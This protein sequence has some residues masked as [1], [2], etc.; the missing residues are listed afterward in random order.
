MFKN[1]EIK[2]N[3]NLFETIFFETIFDYNKDEV[4][5][6]IEKLL[7]H[8]KNILTI[9]INKDN[10]YSIYLTEDL[11]SDVYSYPIF[12]FNSKEDLSQVY[13]YMKLYIDLFSTNNLKI[14]QLKKNMANDRINFKNNLDLLSNQIEE[15]QSLVYS[16]EEQ[17]IIF[18]KIKKIANKNK[19][20]YADN[21]RYCQVGNP[22][23]EYFYKKAFDGGC[24]GFYDSNLVI[25][26][27]E[28]KIGFNYGH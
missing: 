25:N 14:N 12:C 1:L 4:I 5:N 24:C 11:K 28:Y 8:N 19:F 26:E 2:P 7:L 27:V 10:S 21:F 17:K 6:L 20:E 22:L 16:K 15:I 23:Q 3:E 13:H 9:F 18:N